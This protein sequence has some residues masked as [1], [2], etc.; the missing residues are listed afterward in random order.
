MSNS[1]STIEQKK[2]GV[3]GREY[4]YQGYN[5][6]IYSPDMTDALRI[7]KD[8][9]IRERVKNIVVQNSVSANSDT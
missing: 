9:Q 5:V 6:R 8:I 4:P 7:K 1:N 3:L 2:F